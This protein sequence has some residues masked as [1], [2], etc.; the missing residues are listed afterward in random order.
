MKKT[1]VRKSDD[2][3]MVN[4]ETLMKLLSCGRYSAVR[5]GIDA[6]ARVQIGRRVLW[7]VARV[8][9]YVDAISTG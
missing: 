4:T 8:R 1:G 2:A 9:Q 3:I 7:N 6:N 5:V